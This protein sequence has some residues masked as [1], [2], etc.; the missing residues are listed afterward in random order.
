MKGWLI[1]GVTAVAAFAQAPRDLVNQNCLGCHN[2]KLKSGGF[3]WSTLDLT[4]PELNADQAEKVIRKLRAGLMPPPGL[5]RPD[6][7]T[8][9]AFAASIETSIDQAAA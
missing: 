8:M 5:P 1:W 7:A 4:H 6:S 3:S 2:D 9:K